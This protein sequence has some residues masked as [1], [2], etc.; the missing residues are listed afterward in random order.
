MKLLKWLGIGLGGVVALLGLAIAIISVSFDPNAYK[1][2][3][4]RYVKQNQQ[5]TLS[6]PGD[7]H[8]SF[9][10]K[11]GIRVGALS[12]SEFGSDAVF[13]SVAG[14]TVSV[15]LLPLLSKQ[16]VVDRVQVDGL[17]ASIVRGQDGRFNSTISS[18]RAPH[19]KR[20]RP[21]RHRPRRRPF[22]WISTG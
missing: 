11:L 16:V 14:A 21:M 20:R 18:H 19:P 1:D 8:L 7:L 3:I 22:A 15:E 17:S 2:D 5:R 10:P 6:I 13:A 9:Y 4:T 12:L